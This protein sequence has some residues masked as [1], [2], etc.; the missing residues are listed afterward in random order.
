MAVSIFYNVSYTVVPI[1]FSLTCLTVGVLV[2]KPLR[3]NVENETSQHKSDVM[4]ILC[5]YLLLDLVSN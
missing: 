3:P 5:V 2:S 4:T 1:A